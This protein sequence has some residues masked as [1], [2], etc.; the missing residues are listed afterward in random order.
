MCLF[1]S[2][3]MVLSD[4]H[5]T[6]YLEHFKFN[7]YFKII[8]KK[9]RFT[10][11]SLKSLQIQPTNYTI[12][13]HHYTISVSI[14]SVVVCQYFHDYFDFFL[15]MFLLPRTRSPNINPAVSQTK[16][17]LSTA[18]EKNDIKL[19]KSLKKHQPETRVTDSGLTVSD[20]PSGGTATG[21]PYAGAW[22][23]MK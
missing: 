10:Y 14:I 23:F 19:L 5:S 18:Q 12:I 11:L 4:T 16:C 6:E 21:L 7:S 9:P 3:F 13:V 17:H 22:Q 15:F 1:I 20:L 8:L 2:V